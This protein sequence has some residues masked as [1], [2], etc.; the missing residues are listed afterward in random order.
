MFQIMRSVWCGIMWLV[1]CSFSSP[2]SAL[3]FLSLQH[4]SLVTSHQYICPT[5][6][7]RTWVNREKKDTTPFTFICVG[8]S[9]RG[10]ATGSPPMWMDFPYTTPSP[11]VSPSMP[12]MVCWWVKCL[13]VQVCV[14]WTTTS[15]KSL[16]DKTSS[17]STVL[18][19][20]KIHPDIQMETAWTLANYGFRTF[21]QTS[22]IHP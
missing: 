21:F 5:W 6:S 1:F 14:Q 20:G 10:E 15:L 11:A 19:W 7:W 9:T 4:R 12:P 3:S 18:C 17:H 22:N 2:S 8:M 16:T 13:Y